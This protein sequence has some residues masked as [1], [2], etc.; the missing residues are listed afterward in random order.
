MFSIYGA[1]GKSGVWTMWPRFISDTVILKKL[2][3]E[4]R[5]IESDDAAAGAH[6]PHAEESRKANGQFQPITFGFRF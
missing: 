6:R 3:G 4:C 1:G 2:L 5:T